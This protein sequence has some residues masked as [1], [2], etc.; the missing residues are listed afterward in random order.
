[1][2]QGRAG[3][4]VANPTQHLSSCILYL[5]G[6]GFTGQGFRLPEK[7]AGGS[8]SITIL[9]EQWLVQ[10]FTFRL[11]LTV[12]RGSL[13]TLLGGPYAVPGIEQGLIIC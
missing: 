9:A 13:M 5:Q 1:M 7:A 3:V 10:I 6:S 2:E 11:D 8:Q 12:P 4:L